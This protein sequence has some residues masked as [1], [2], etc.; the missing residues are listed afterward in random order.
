MIG[1]SG[2]IW[3][4]V[5]PDDTAWHAGVSMNPTWQNLKHNV[6]PNFYTIGIEHEGFTG[7]KWTASM[8]ESSANLIAKL[9]KDYNIPC[10]DKFIIG[11]NQINSINRNNCPGNGVDLPSLINKA[12]NILLEE[13]MIEDLKR[14]IKELNQLIQ[15][16]KV[17][18]NNLIKQLSLTESQQVKSLLNENDK[19]RKEILK[20]QNQLNNRTKSNNFFE[21]LV[22]IF[23]N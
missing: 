17:E 21:S 7:E 23:R 13:S 12:K 22:K 10:N 20:L 5:H 16:Q 11:H 3:Q 14:Q 2:E 18:I 8:I 6:N 15:D 4:F 9:C 1:K 19:L